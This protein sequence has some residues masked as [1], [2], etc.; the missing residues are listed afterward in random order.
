MMRERLEPIG[1][2]FIS[3]WD[4]MCNAEGCLVRSAGSNDKM[5]ISAT[6]L[7][8]LS[9]TGSAFLIRAIERDIFAAD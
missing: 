5:D 6:D 8:H 1:V 7:L 2:T 4:A 3:A 9:E